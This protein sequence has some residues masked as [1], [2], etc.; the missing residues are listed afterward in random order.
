DYHTAAD[1]TGWVGLLD[2]YKVE[3]GRLVCLKETQGNI[4][5]EKDFADF[6]LRLDFRMTAAANN[7]VGIRTPN[8]KQASVYG[9]AIQILDDTAP[10]YKTLKPYQLC[11]AIYNCVPPEQGHLKPVGEWN[12]Y[13]IIA[14]GR[15]VTVKLNGATVCEAD[16]DKV[17]AAGP[18]DGKDHPGLKNVTGR[19]A[20]LGHKALVEFRN[21][22]VKEL[23]AAPAK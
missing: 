15:K 21:L 9:M 4:Y 13:E 2:G 17:L 23:K 6:V 12:A 20:I 10:A 7:G 19:I 16:L 22:R 11:G 5:T 3:D 1:L 14:K 18:A 8:G